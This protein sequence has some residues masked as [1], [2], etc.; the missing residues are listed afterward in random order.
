MRYY[1]L[2]VRG[3]LCKTFRQ[4]VITLELSQTPVIRTVLAI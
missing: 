3:A 1:A 2:R 4:K